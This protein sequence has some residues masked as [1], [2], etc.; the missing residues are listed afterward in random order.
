MMDVDNMKY[1][2]RRR[3][4]GVLGRFVFI[5]CFTA[6]VKYLF[7]AL[8]SRDVEIYIVVLLTAILVYFD[9]PKVVHTHVYKTRVALRDRVK[10]WFG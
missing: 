5:V 9:P 4:P 10:G 8:T 2:V 1:H 7:G 6:S 3:A